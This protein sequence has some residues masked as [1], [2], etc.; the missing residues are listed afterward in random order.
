MVWNERHLVLTMSW[1]KYWEVVQIK[2]S[3]TQSVF[4]RK[5]S[6]F[7]IVFEISC[8]RT[9]SLLVTVMCGNYIKFTH[10]W[11]RWVW[12]CL[13]ISVWHLFMNLKNNYLLKKQFKGVNKKWKK[14]IFL[15][16]IKKNPW[17]YHYFTPV[18]QKSWWYDL[19][20]LTYRVWQT[21]IGNY[22]SFFAL[23]HPLLKTQKIRI[24]KKWKKLL[25]ISSFFTCTKNHNHKRYI[26]LN[27]IHGKGAIEF[28]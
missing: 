20:F 11:R 1:L 6:P 4:L 3:V 9:L 5:S 10:M 16:K 21:K 18:Y 28:F 24:L 14:F 22:G 12:V 13:R 7:P 8:Y 25:E 19:Q 15:K 17:R 27:P 23:L 26:Q 2:I